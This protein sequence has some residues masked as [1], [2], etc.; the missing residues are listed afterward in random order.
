MLGLAAGQRE[1]GTFREPLRRAADWL[2]TTQD[3]DKCWRRHASPFTA[4]GDKVYDTHIAWG[5]LEAGAVE[6]GR[7]YAAVA[8]AN[9]G[10]ALTHQHQDGF[11]KKCCL[12]N[13]T[14]PLTHTLGYALRGII[15]AYRAS[16]NAELLAASRLTADGLIKCLGEDGFLPGRIAPGWRPAVDWVCLTGTAQIAYCWLTLY[17]FTGEGHYLDAG[18]CANAF[19]RRTV[20][21][22]GPPECQGGVKSSFPL[23]GDYQRSRY[24]NWAAKFLH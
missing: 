13:T 10:W 19:V 24:P 11:F 1:C 12:N 9:I 3:L 18:R 23:D 22:T 8:M 17:T 7:S 16:H 5:L 6:R 4:P 20:R 14:R 21:V 2:V 15:E